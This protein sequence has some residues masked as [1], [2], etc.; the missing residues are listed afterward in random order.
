MKLELQYQSIQQ[1][2]AQPKEALHPAPLA[3]LAWNNYD[4]QTIN[5]NDVE[6]IHIMQWRIWIRTGK[7]AQVISDAPPLILEADQRNSTRVSIK[8]RILLAQALDATGQ[9]R[10]ALNALHTVFQI[11]NGQKLVSIFIEE[12]PRLI[13]LLEKL[14]VEPIEPAIQ[15]HVRQILNLRNVFRQSPSGDAHSTNP[16]AEAAP[17]TLVIKAIDS[18]SDRELQILQCLAAGMPNKGIAGKLFITEPTVKFHLRNINSKLRAK[19]RTHAV[20]IGRQ[21]GLIQ[22]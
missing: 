4:Q 20:F 19:N 5:A 2:D 6:T 22:S 12:G 16:H 3:E 15:M 10:A 14:A 21:L 7:S 9:T 11:M 13:A 1:F 17:A 8:L 18:L